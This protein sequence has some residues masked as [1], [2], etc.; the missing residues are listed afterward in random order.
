MTNTQIYKLLKKIL[1]NGSERCYRGRSQ[2]NAL[3]VAENTKATKCG[4]LIRSFISLP[5]QN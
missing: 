2:A 1:R 3:S 4:D 5:K